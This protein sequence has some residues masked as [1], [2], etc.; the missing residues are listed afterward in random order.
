MGIK[1]KSNEK[2]FDS[3]STRMAYVL[4]YIY[5]DGYILY[6]PNMRGK[7]MSVTSIDRD[8]IE[9][10]KDWLDSDH[11]ITER[12]SHWQNGNMA[13]MI[14]VGS[15]AL[16]D[17]LVRRG[18]YQNKSLTI[19]LPEIPQEYFMDFVRGYFDGDGCV[20]L[21][22]ILRKDGKLRPRKLNVIF[23][24]GS[25][26][27]LNGLSISLHEIAGVKPQK[28]L[29]AWTAFQLRYG[30]NDSILLYGALYK[31]SKKGEYLERKHEIFEEFFKLHKRRSGEDG[32]H[33]S[34]QNCHARVRIPP[35]PHR[36]ILEYH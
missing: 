20:H 24:S 7:Y 10:I 30:T 26:E 29:R 35:T 28:T 13:Y 5:A 15:H 36:N 23:T 8:S 12:K 27:F 6:A 11:R 22:K 32:Q 16:Y 34:L 4:G 21:E 25:K 1:Y 31:D 18:L 2:F 17:S 9:R 33:S 3:W 19:T 14:R